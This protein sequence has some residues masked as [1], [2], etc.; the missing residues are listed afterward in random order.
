MKPEPLSPERD[1][2]DRRAGRGACILMLAGLSCSLLHFLSQ[3]A[4]SFALFATLGFAT[5]GLG[6][7]L[8]GIAVVRELRQRKVL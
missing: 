6:L 1:P 5:M 2:G 3:S 8:Y 4:W 7:L